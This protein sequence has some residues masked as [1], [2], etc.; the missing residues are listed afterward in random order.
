[1]SKPLLIIFG[2]S[3][4]DI[5]KYGEAYVYKLSSLKIKSRHRFEILNNPEKL[6]KF[7]DQVKNPYIK[8]I[9]KIGNNYLY[10]VVSRFISF[11]LFLFGDLSSMRNEVYM[12]FNGLCNIKIIRAQIKKKKPS[13]IYFI[14]LPIEYENILKNNIRKK[15][16]IINNSFLSVKLFAKK[17]FIFAKVIFN[18]IYFLSKNIIAGIISLFFTRNN[19]HNY[20]KEDLNIFVTRFPLHFKDSE[21]DEKYSSMFIKNKKNVYL[22]DLISDG[23]HQN[24]SIRKYITSLLK[25]SKFNSKFILLDKYLNLF[26]LIFIL[27]KIPI[28]ILTYL[29]LINKRYFFEDINLSYS[30]QIELIYSMSKN[31]RLLFLFAKFK[32][33]AKNSSIKKVFY[34]IFEYPY[35]RLIS[36]SFNRF[37]NI[38][39]IGVQHGPS[40]SRKLFHYSSL[41]VERQ[42]NKKYSPNKILCEDKYSQ[43]IYKKSNYKKISV[44]KKIPRLSYLD[45]IKNDCTGCNVIFGGLHDSNAIL[46]ELEDYIK[47]SSQKFLFKPH[48]RSKINSQTK[49][50][51]QTLKNIEIT[52]KHVKDLLK[53]CSAVFCTYSSLGYEAALLGIEVKL[54]DIPGLV[55]LS[56]LSDNN[57]V[58]TEK[59]VTKI[60]FLSRNY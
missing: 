44:M 59:I 38:K 39:T 47:C 5:S 20:D 53:S 4:V 25:L 32:K 9:R 12:N 18:L 49:K 19:F 10:R 56:Q 23:I 27:I 50:I 8:W 16:Y 41:T 37:K 28:I 13:K 55:N 40:S 31:I 15:D 35:G 52:H 43:N 6:D 24:L 21:K 17:Y 42:I 46:F 51:I 57:F 14:N 29:I 1:M 11:N 58:K 30:I 60:E 33:V 45:K 3:E 34:T 54:I 22:I 36:Y 7:A 48:P 26:D 2:N